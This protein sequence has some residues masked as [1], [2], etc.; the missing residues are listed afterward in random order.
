MRIV[1]FGQKLSILCW[2]FQ[3]Q[4]SDDVNAREKG[5]IGGKLYSYVSQNKSKGVMVPYQ[6][7]HDNSYTQ[8]KKSR[9]QQVWDTPV[10]KNVDFSSLIYRK[11]K[12]EGRKRREK[13]EEKI[14]KGRGDVRRITSGIKP[15][16]SHFDSSLVPGVVTAGLM[17]SSS[18]SPL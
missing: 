13:K 12:R 18:R 9:T 5:K 3:S 8:A 14:R 11:E 10:T 6:F 16:P 4:N 7:R 15:S 2:I 1:V 17:R